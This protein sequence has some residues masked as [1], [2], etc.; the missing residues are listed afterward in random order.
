MEGAMLTF[1]FL[2]SNT[3]PS[4]N[5]TV[6]KDG[7]TVSGGRINIDGTGLTINTV[8]RTDSGNYTIMVTTLA[9]SDSISFYLDVYCEFIYKHYYRD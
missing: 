5:L 9:G 2:I 6:T 3:H 8:N 7:Q 1:R 4:S